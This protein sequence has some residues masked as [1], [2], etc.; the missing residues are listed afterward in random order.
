MNDD[1][2]TPLERALVGELLTVLDWIESLPDDEIDPDTA[3]KIQEDIAAVVQGL[4]DDERARFVAV[5]SS[6]ADEADASRPGAGDAFRQALDAMGLL[7][8]A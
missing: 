3:V 2:S 5:A 8:E 1:M 6:L 7:D 4:G